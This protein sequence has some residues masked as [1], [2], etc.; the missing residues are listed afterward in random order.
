MFL[1]VSLLVA[2]AE[3]VAPLPLAALMPRADAMSPVLSPSGEQLLWTR[4]VHAGGEEEED[5]HTLCL[6]SLHAPFDCQPLHEGWTWTVGW[7]DE[8]RAV[9]ARLANDQ[10]AWSVVDVRTGAFAVDVA[11]PTGAV[12]RSAGADG[13]I[14]TGERGRWRWVDRFA[15]DG[16]AS[17]RLWENRHHRNALLSAGTVEGQIRTWGT[18]A[19]TWNVEIRS[20][21]GR[22]LMRDGPEHWFPP[23]QGGVRVASRRP[24]DGRLLLFDSRERDPAALV[25]LDLETGEPETVWEGEDWPVDVFQDEHGR[26]LAVATRRVR[27]TWHA[28]DSEVAEDLNWLSSVLPGDLWFGDTRA[29]GSVWTVIRH[30]A[31]RP[32]EVWHIDRRARQ[33]TRLPPR[34]GAFEDRAWRPSEFVDVEARDGLIVPAVWTTPDPSVW[35]EGPWPTV[36]TLHGGPWGDDHAD[37][38]FE[39]LTQYWA[40]LGFA[41]VDP[42]FRG[43]GGVDLAYARAWEGE[44]GDAMVTDIHDVT[45]AAIEAG[46]ADPERVAYLGMSYGGYAVLRSA[47]T[48]GDPMTCGVSWMGPARLGTPMYRLLGVTDRRRIAPHHA[49]GSVDTP[50]L[51]IMGGRDRTVPVR[52]SRKFLRSAAKAGADVSFVVFPRQGHGLDE[53][54]FEQ[55]L[56]LS[57]RFL[58]RCLGREAPSGDLPED[59]AFEVRIDTRHPDAGE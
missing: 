6:S 25:A 2:S 37:G 10:A 29:D 58:S 56:T 9:V 11:L 53:A 34:W 28:L 33:L 49:A 42:Q 16:A 43:T 12:V 4:I 22:R 23:I 38:S 36:V 50:L 40:H 24:W 20:A 32:I 55:A 44:F 3:P 41:V 13:V 19:W 54:A 31:Q 14:V 45:R 18:P 39:E 1:L 17:E 48:E 57:A 47:T 46:I 27:R 30:A 51:A 35:G 52:S 26:P 8:E 21:D 59:P 7:L 15:L 5:H